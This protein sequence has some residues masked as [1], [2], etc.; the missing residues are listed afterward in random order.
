[1]SGRDKGK[2]MNKTLFGTTILASTA[3]VALS[4]SS[5]SAAPIEA[6]VRGFHV[7][8]FAGAYQS[9]DPV[10]GGAD[11]DVANFDHHF[12]NEIHFRGRSALDNGLTVGFRVELEGRTDDDQIDEAYIFVEGD[13]FG[14]FYIGDENAAQ[15]LMHF[16][17][18]VPTSVDTQ[19]TEITFL[20]GILPG[21]FDLSDTAIDSTLNRANDNDS[22]KIGY[23]TPRIAGF[24]LGVSYAAIAEGGGDDNS[25]DR[26]GDQWNN[27]SVGVTY[28]R[29]FNGVG[30]GL[31]GGIVYADT[32][33]SG[34]ANDSDDLYG[35]NTGTFVSFDG[36]TI[37]G[38]FAYMEGDEGVIDRG[39]TDRALLFDSWGYNVSVTYEDGPYTFGIGY[40][41]GK[42]SGLQG[43]GER[44]TL[45]QVLIGMTYTLGPGV[46]WELTGMY[47]DAEGEKRDEADIVAV[48]DG[49]SDYQRT[50][51][52]GL[53]TS[54]SLSF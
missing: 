33:Q 34:P 41:R 48:G 9:I 6:S 35:V 38:S 23:F 13:N 27:A 2:A 12:D 7:E 39:T 18:A 28:E 19:E 5:V 25:S 11:A 44:N 32:S 40:Q 49:P 15:Y 16:D 50:D 29:E 17:P 8:Y 53:T 1:M 24:Q 54:I 10:P 37:G 30:F 45:D 47:W 31:S 43:D 21:S 42:S 20:N 26:T 3:V 36:F 4:A 22:G 14:R 52:A 46:D 51:G